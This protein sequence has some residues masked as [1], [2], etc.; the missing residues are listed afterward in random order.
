MRIQSRWGQP[1]ER[2]ILSFEQVKTER[3]LLGHPEHIAQRLIDLNRELGVEFVFLHVYTPGMDP[4]EALEMVSRLGEETLPIVRRVVGRRSL[5]ASSSESGGP[6]SRFGRDR[7]P[8]AKTGRVLGGAPD[9]AA[10][11]WPARAD[12][13]GPVRTLSRRSDGRPTCLRAANHP[14]QPCGLRRRGWLRKMV[15]SDQRTTAHARTTESSAG[16]RTAHP[17]VISAAMIVTP[18]G[19]RATAP[20]RPSSRR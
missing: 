15:S 14:G 17:P 16:A 10:A 9:Q 1:G 20:S 2:S 12:R 5:F 19:E 3:I 8:V 6:T 7:R 18:I 13:R 4:A 11:R